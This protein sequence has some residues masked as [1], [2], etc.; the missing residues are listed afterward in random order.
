[1]ITKRLQIHNF[2]IKSG[3]IPIFDRF[4]LFMARPFFVLLSLSL[5]ISAC[6]QRLICP[7]YQSA[8]IY[9]KDE[10]RKK[11]S[12]FQEDSTPKILTASKTR[13]LIAEPVS[14]RKK[15]RS[16]QTVQMKD[17]NPKLPDS[18]KVGEEEGLMGEDGVVPG[19][20]LD[21]A[22]RSVIDSTYIIDVPQ[23]TTQ[24]EGDSLYVITKD[25]ELRLLKYDFPDSLR[26][27]ESSGK[28]VPK[29]PTYAVGDVRFNVEQDNY[30]WYLRNNLVLPDVRLA[31]VAQKEDKSAKAKKEKKGF[32]KNLFKR[33]K[34]DAVDSTTLQE[35]VKSEDDFDYIDE[36][37]QDKPASD[38]QEEPQKKKG[39]FSFLKK[40]D[41]TT[42]PK[43]D[44]AP[45]DKKP[46][47]LKK[48]KKAKKVKDVSKPEEV[49]EE[50]EEDDGF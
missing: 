25:K 36:N 44:E 11:F 16:M 19:A 50:E 32:F 35:P 18:L 43:V 6:T 24:L 48:E 12:Y 28:Y 10:L 29:T 37:A 49:T 20:E 33:K 3:K 45:T 2:K 4:T 46:K 23:D 26:Y 47:K 39:L 1:M 21:L 7:A 30:M 17:V 22:A 34:K 15:I 13:Y 27:D 9:D 41:K 14:Y 38:V 42:E 40:K 31:Q 5:L 8:F